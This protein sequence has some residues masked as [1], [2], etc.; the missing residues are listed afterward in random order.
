MSQPATLKMIVGCFAI[1]CLVL[2]GCG[3]PPPVVAPVK[4]MVTLDGNP[5]PVGEILFRGQGT[6]NSM[7]LNVNAGEFAG[8]VQ[9]GKYKIEVYSYTMIQ[10]T[11]DATGYM[12]SEPIKQNTIPPQWNTM[13]VVVIDVPQGGKEDFKFAVTSR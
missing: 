2:V 3:E 7:T 5:M 11:A 10:P 9:P 1:G 4:G 13:S 6:P 12:P 8:D